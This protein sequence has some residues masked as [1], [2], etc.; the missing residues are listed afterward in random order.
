[1]PQLRLGTGKGGTLRFPRERVMRWLRQRESQ[2][3]ERPSRKQMPHRR[4]ATDSIDL[5][6]LTRG[7]LRA[8]GRG[9]PLPAAPVQ[10]VGARHHLYR[11]CCCAREVRVA[12]GKREVLSEQAAQPV[13]LNPD[14]LVAASSLPT[15]VTGRRGLLQREVHAVLPALQRARS[16]AGASTASLGPLKREVRPLLCIV[17]RT[18]M[19][20]ETYGSLPTTQLSCGTCGM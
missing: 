18:R 14:V 1:M 2:L 5:L 3:A 13:G 19:W 9:E 11:H 8:D 12:G 20:R 17:V 10:S 16:V 15:Q 7:E 4:E 6:R